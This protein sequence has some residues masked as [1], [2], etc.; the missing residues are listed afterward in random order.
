M[1]LFECACENAEAIRNVGLIAIAEAPALGVP[2]HYM[3]PAVCDGTRQQVKRIDDEE[4][5][6]ADLP[7]R[8]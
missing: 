2:V 1:K 5:V 3:G 7:P 4:I 8:L 6:I